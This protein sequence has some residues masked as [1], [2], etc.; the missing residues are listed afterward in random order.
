MQNNGE[1]AN[2]H[3]RSF[4]FISPFIR[5]LADCCFVSSPPSFS[6]CVFNFRC[7]KKKKIE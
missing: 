2:L 3:E 7:K 5:Q 4:F 1:R 6:F